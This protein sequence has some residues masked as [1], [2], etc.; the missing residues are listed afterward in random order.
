[1]SKEKKIRSICIDTLTAIMTDQYI[2][3]A[4][5][6]GFDKWVDLSVG[7]W[8][9]VTAIQDMGFELILIVGKSGT[10]KSTGMM[11]LPHNTN[12]WYNMDH[13]NPSWTGGRREYGTKTNPRSPFHVLPNSYSDVISHIK[14]GI[15][16]GKFEEDRYAILT[17]HM[18]QDKTNKETDVRLRVVGNLTKRLELEN[19]LETVFYTNITREE[20]KSKFVLETISD[21]SNTAKSPMHPVNE[22]EQLFDSII[23]NDYNF[24]INK[25]IE[26]NTLAV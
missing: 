7:L 16:G 22:D 15:E 11:R 26:L 17:G 5:K 24:V 19:K 23:P 8:Q 4:K 21:G 3:K 25:L 12:I 18:E 2:A 9:F 10:G 20:K 1:M 13:K 14:G 6:P